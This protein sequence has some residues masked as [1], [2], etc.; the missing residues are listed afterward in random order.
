M[1]RFIRTLTIPVEMEDAWAFFSD[2]KSLYE[3]TPAEMQL[4]LE[5][6]GTSAVSEGKRFI[7]QVNPL[8]LLRV[9]WESEI[10]EVRERSYFIDRQ[11]EGPFA[12]WQHHHSFREVKNGV[13]VTDEIDYQVPF[14]KLGIW[15]NE[16]LI[17][18]KIARLFDYRTEQ[19]KNKFG[20]VE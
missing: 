3:L 9:K 8:P 5:I 11:V 16:I 2:I 19:L 20:L 10:V 14:G 18:K 12:S 6:E 17:R 4:N 13:E 1:H 7:S 15:T